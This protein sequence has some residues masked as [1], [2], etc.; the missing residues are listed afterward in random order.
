LDLNNIDFLSFQIYAGCAQINPI[1]L[2]GI[3]QWLEE[4]TSKK[5]I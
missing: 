1:K 3:A 2:D 5:Q 4:L